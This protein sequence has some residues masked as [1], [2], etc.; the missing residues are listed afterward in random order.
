MAGASGWTARE[1]LAVGR[2]LLGATLI[3]FAPVFVRLTSVG[4]STSAFYRVL[5]GGLILVV[6][7]TAAG[8]KL[9][10]RGLTLAMLVAA[11]FFFAVDLFVWHRSIILVGPGLA[12][13]LGNF[14]VFLMALA[15][16]LFFG[17]RLRP[18]FVISIL[19]AVTGLTMIVG[20]DWAGLPPGY[21]AGVAF[22]LAT[23]VAYAAYMLSLRQAHAVEPSR[24]LSVHLAIASLLTAAFLGAAMG[25]TGESFVIPT[26]RDAGLLVAY[27][28]VAQVLGW[29]FIAS[30]LPVLPPSRVGLILLLQPTLAFVWD[31]LIFARGFTP[32][33]AAG[34]VVALIAIYLGSQRR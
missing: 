15:G 2:V 5:F 16:V 26:W 32:L 17:E 28:A 10:A 12:T 30:S 22:G 19:L 7:V 24:D 21:L 4:P 31:V 20:V 29:L 13:L 3:S 8:K 1:S 6:W 27:G 25:L 34:V 11:G 18:I 14:Q 9:S 23:A 33:E